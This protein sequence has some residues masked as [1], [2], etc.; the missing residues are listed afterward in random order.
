MSKGKEGGISEVIVCLYSGDLKGSDLLVF[1][2]AVYLC[3]YI[4]Q[5]GK[6]LRK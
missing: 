2:K 4:I 3:R 6:Q 1:P 5:K